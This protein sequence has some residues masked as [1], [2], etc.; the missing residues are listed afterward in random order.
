MGAFGRK[1][2]LSSLGA[3]PDRSQYIFVRTSDTRTWTLFKIESQSFGGVPLSDNS[4]TFSG[5]R[6]ER[7]VSRSSRG[8]A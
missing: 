8:I 1:R 2:K 4:T 6:A 3:I 5:L 7:T